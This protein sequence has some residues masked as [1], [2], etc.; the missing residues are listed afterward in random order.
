MPD[1]SHSRLT[2]KLVLGFCALTASSGV[3]AFVIASSSTS[4][5][6][7]ARLRPTIY[8]SQVTRLESVARLERTSRLSQARQAFLANPT[9]RLLEKQFAANG[10]RVPHPMSMSESDSQ[11]GITVEGATLRASEARKVSEQL[12]RNFAVLARHHLARG[13]SASPQLP[14]VV[15]A[16]LVA[17]PYGLN[18]ADAAWVAFP[19]GDGA[20]VIPGSTGTCL[21]VSSDDTEVCNGVSA[22]DS[23]SLLLLNGAQDGGTTSTSII[24]L[25]PDTTTSVAIAL[26]NGTTQ[27]VS[28]SE[29]VYSFTT[30]DLP[31]SVTLNDVTGSPH[32][33]KLPQ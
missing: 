8:T 2:R 13:A 4:V 33:W 7:A 3:I 19:G 32:T 12:S 20:W 26:A 18:V 23:G 9:N 24:G 30:S 5:A 14:G 29:N 28:P 17:S 15:V 16:S 21:V 27:F 1:P 22:A 31:V 11:T 25:A 10:D 6:G